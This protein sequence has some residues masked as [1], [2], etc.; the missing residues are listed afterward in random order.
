L[1]QTATVSGALQ[2]LVDDGFPRN[3]GRVAAIFIRPGVNER[4]ELQQATLTASEG[5]RGDRWNG[6]NP[7]TQITMMNAL[8]LDCVCGGDRSRWQLA[9][10]QLI[11]DL[12]I[13]EE[14]LP[15]GQH[16]QAGEVRLEV[17]DIP[18]T[19][20]NKF[21]ARYGREALDYINGRDRSH[22]RLRGV[23]VRVVQDGTLRVGDEIIK[24]ESVQGG[25]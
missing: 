16:L 4:E 8:V 9:G 20:C 21:K 24:V 11:V 14:N 22:L 12:D 10:D 23:Y 13:S 3:C 7:R 25:I 6:R 15:I 17:S 19:G 1:S 18:H 5:V 2:R